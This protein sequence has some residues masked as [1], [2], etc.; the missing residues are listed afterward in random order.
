MA[1]DDQIEGVHRPFELDLGLHTPSL[2]GLGAP[3]AA[4]AGSLEHVLGRRGSGERSG[5]AGVEAG[6][7]VGDAVGQQSGRLRRLLLLPEGRG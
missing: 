1:G 6:F 2:G 3:L 4:E 7:Q 5:A